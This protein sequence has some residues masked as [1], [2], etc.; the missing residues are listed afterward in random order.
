M[1]IRPTRLPRIR[2]QVV[3][4]LTDQDSPFFNGT[5]NAEV[6][7]D[8]DVAAALAQ[9]ARHLSVGGL[10][11]ATSDMAALAT[12]AGRSLEQ[13]DLCAE[14]RPSGTGLLVMDGGVG[15]VPY[16]DGLCI[17]IDAVSWGPSDGGLM[18][19]L[20]L[21]RYQIEQA[22]AATGNTLMSEN[23][24]PLVP[25]VWGSIPTRPYPVAEVCEEMRTIV[26]TMAA[27]WHLMRQPTLTD[28]Q[29]LPADRNVRRAYA[30][31]G[32]PE[33]EVTIVDLR[34]LYR[35]T[36]PD[37]K[38]DVEPG[39]YSHRWVVR[40]HWRDQAHGP[41][42]SLRKRIWIPDYLKGPDGAPLLV[43]ERVNVWRR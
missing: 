22:A 23:V 6:R 33:P 37:H 9:Q 38:P 18:V 31:A 28:R 26:A 16:E 32:R 11:C 4:A 19:T 24:A 8:D 42:R 27:A 13:V 1:A 29:R 34:A 12:A 3:A 10:T 14:N 25:M 43:R 7:A 41:E 39:R 20:W 35:P 40:G 2:D 30:R 15:R 5:V 21:A 17:P 36:D